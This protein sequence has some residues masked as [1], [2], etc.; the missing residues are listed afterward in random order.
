MLRFEI[1][2]QELH[3]RDQLN[4]PIMLSPH[5]PK[6]VPVS[7]PFGTSCMYVGLY[8]AVKVHVSRYADL[9]GPQ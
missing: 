4:V 6:K 9:A 2:H 5:L 1:L 7:V 8:Q 3:V